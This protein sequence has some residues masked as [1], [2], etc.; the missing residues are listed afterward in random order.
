MSITDTAQR[1]HTEYIENNGEISGHLQINVPR[2]ITIK[3][4][5]NAVHRTKTTQNHEIT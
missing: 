4:S 3:R 1:Q 2:R 5:T